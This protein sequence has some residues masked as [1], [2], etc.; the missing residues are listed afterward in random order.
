MIPST[1]LGLVVLAAAL[2]PGYIF[3]RVEER[4]RPRPERSALLETAELIVIGGLASTLAFA[5]V[6]G[7][8]AHTRW[9][10]EKKLAAHP[11]QYLLSHA[12]RFA[13]LLLITLLLSCIASFLAAIALFHG[14]PATIKAH[15]AWDQVLPQQ[16]GIINYATVGLDDG[17]AVAGDVVGHSVGERPPDNRELILANPEFRAVG[18][19]VFTRAKDQFVVL[20][21]DRIRTFAV[22]QYQGVLPKADRPQ[23]S[24]QRLG[25]A[26]RWLTTVP[27]RGGSSPTSATPPAP[28]AT[29]AP[30]APSPQDQAPQA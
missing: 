2:G 17:L 25:S 15:S 13:A 22:I 11:T 23:T 14:Y 19:K 6:A 16:P 4:R 5:A 8:T 26:W 9:L 12:S 30:G 28:A 29:G 24:R 7:V 21:G 3:V 1:V 10:D 18:N 20:R 27:P